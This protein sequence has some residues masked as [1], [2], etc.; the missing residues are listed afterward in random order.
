MTI[1]RTVSE[2]GAI[3]E[4]IVLSQEEERAMDE[5][6]RIIEE[7]AL[8][9]GAQYDYEMVEWWLQGMLRSGGIDSI[10]KAA[11]TTPFQRDSKPKVTVGYCY[12]FSI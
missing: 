11:K 9:E 10:L 8:S 3:T 5:A 1:E 6:H 12:E 4:H 7:R 2:T